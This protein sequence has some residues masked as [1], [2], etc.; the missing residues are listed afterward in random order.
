[1]KR[2]EM[3][4]LMYEFVLSLHEYDT[5]ISEYNASDLLQKM[6]DAGM[7]PPEFKDYN[8]SDAD[9]YLSNDG[10]WGWDPGPDGKGSFLIQRGWEPESKT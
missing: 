5:Y 10:D 2:S 6:E 8:P 7:L 1:M 4:E 9:R 3:V